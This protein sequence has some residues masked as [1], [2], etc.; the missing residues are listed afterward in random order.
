[1]VYVLKG[2]LVSEFEGQGAIQMDVGSCWLQPSGIRHAVLD[3]SDY[4][5][6]LEIVMPANFSTENL[7]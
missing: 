1:M 2:W 7:E 3:Y 6:I 5:E 4:C